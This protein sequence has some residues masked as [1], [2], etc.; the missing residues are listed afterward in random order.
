MWFTFDEVRGMLTNIQYLP[1]MHLLYALKGFEA[2]CM[3]NYYNDI[4]ACIPKKIHR[5]SVFLYLTFILFTSKYTSHMLAFIVSSLTH[6]GCEYS[7]FRTKPFIGIVVYMS[8]FLV[9]ER[10][11]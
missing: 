11:F 4:A 10:R 3:Y 2:V 1:S 8:T 7:V 9:I 5:I 6:K